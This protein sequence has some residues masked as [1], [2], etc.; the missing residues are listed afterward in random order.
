MPNKRLLFLLIHLMCGALWGQ[1]GIE[2]IDTLPLYE[3][4]VP[5]PEATL[6]KTLLYATLIPGGGHFYT[7]HKVRGSFLLA[8]QGILAVDAYYT[9]PFQQQK[10]FD[11]TENA[12]SE[13]EFLNRAILQNPFSDSITSWNSRRRILLAEIRTQNDLKLQEEDLRKSEVAWLWGLHLYGVLDAWGI[14]R[15]NQGR[16]VETREVSSALWRS[17][18]VPG[19]G[20]FYNREYG[21]AGLL[22]MG[23]WGSIVSFRT[24][25]DMVEYYLG[26]KNIALAEGLEREAIYAQ[27][28]VTFFRKRRNQY[29]WGL[30]LMY[31]YS[32]GDAVV[33]AMLSDFDS[34]FYLTILPR[35]GDQWHVSLEWVF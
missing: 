10:R 33:D 8:I 31:L 27:E 25:Q 18:L 16:S 22:Y 12:R 1:S 11:L 14:W 24:R 21:K 9:K 26:R 28:K 5:A 30:F 23:I 15:N 20:Q 13:L 19:W 3:W 6:G 2:A 7:N 32:I 29:S 4:D 35:T 17:A 34:P